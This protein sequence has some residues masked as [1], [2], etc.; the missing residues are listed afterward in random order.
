MI[1][2]FKQL[3][4][5][6]YQDLSTYFDYIIESMNNG[7]ISQAVDLYK[8]LCNEYKYKFVFYCKQEKEINVFIDI[9]VILLKKDT[10]SYSF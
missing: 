2:T 5:K 7:Q 4:R 3:N 10:V 9:Q 8:A 6:G 1:K